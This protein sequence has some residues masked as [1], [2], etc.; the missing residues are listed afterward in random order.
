V[1][2]PTSGARV[3]VIHLSVRSRIAF[4]ITLVL[5]GT[6]ALLLGATL[7]LALLG[8]ALAAGAIGAIVIGVRRLLGGGEKRRSRRLD[9]SMEVFPEPRRDA[10]PG[11]GDDRDA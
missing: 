3:R 7:L 10:L 2:E 4:A 9:P 1:T 8:V 11:D 5:G 6:L